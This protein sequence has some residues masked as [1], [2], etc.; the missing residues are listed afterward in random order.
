MTKDPH[1]GNHTFNGEE[2]FMYQG[3]PVWIIEESQ[4]YDFMILAEYP[5]GTEINISWTRLESASPEDLD[6]II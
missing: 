6:G 2:L 3:M 4:V 1:T 5:N